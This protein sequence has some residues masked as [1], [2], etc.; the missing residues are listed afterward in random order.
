MKF[1]IPYTTFHN[2]T[3]RII[4]S[5]LFLF[6][7]FLTMQAQV[8]EHRNRLAIGANG[9]YSI[10]SVRFTPEIPQGHITGFTGG[11]SMRYTCE[12]YFKTICSIYGEVNLNTM[13][14]K[15]NILDINDQ[16]VINE[17]TGLEEKYSRSIK[18]IQVP[19]MA[20]LSWGKEIQGWSFFFRGGPQFGFYQSES[21]TMNFDPEYRNI[22]ARACKVVE[23]ETLPLKNKFDYGITGGIG[24]EYSHH[25][26]GHLLFEARYYYG[27]G[28]IY[29]D[30]SADTFGSSNHQNIQLKVSYLFDIIKK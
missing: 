22:D 13:G 21:V 24:V 8:G 30:S 5:F 17:Q 11:L 23:Q 10:S 1:Y 4:F 28:N 27:L 15:E 25:T 26:A 19:I 29:A 9:G 20:Q 3:Q 2:P 6:G 14:W 12:K 7:F 18:Y 16:P